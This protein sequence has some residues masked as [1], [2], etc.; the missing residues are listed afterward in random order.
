VVGLSVVLGVGC[1]PGTPGATERTLEDTVSRT[2]SA[3][4]NLVANGSFET[5]LQGWTTWQATL[6]RE[7]RTGAPDGGYVV[8]VTPAA[9][10]SGGFSIDDQTD[11]VA[12]PATVGTYS[13]TAYVAAASASSVGKTIRV[14]LREKS[15]GVSTRVWEQTVTL[16]QTFQKVT[17]TAT[18]TQT[19]RSMDFYV[20][21][22]AGTSTDAFYADALSVTPPTVSTGWNLVFQD[23]FSGTA[24]DTTQWGMYYSPGHDGNGLRRPSA[25]S[26]ANGMLVVTAQMIDGVL[27]S[28]G[29]AHRTNYQYGRFEFRV[30]T[31]A[32]PSSATSGVVLTWPG[33][34]NW[35][36]DG[37]NDMYETGTS[38]SRANFSTFIHYGANNSQYYYTHSNVD[39]TQWHI[40]AME[41]EADALRIY[42]DGVLVW[43]LT[44]KAAI[45][46]VAHHLC[47]QLDA[48]RT[49]MGSPVRMY[50]D[51][52]KIYQR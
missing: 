28:G 21:Q 29:M 35:P 17:V 50:V 51:W 9:G 6:T 24:V 52:V 32:D 7:A 12:A 10:T 18:I 2:E 23:D 8:K 40:V 37:E 45:P 47:I 1:G 5:S 33:S 4:T 22:D 42:R 14:A 3:V 30:R 39:A 43:T 19:G 48:F 44:D 11:T 41:W 25:F 49:T 16:T 31:E 20:F 13:A 46:D 26:V 15:A 34:G 27:V 36:V 38:A